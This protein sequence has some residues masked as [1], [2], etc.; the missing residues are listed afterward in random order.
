MQHCLEQTSRA[1]L[2]VAALGLCAAGPMRD[3]PSNL[4]KEIEERCNA[5]DLERTP[6][7]AAIAKTQN[8]LDGYHYAHDRERPWTRADDPARRDQAIQVVR[9]YDNLILI[10]NAELT[11]YQSDLTALSA[12]HAS[13]LNNL[14]IARAEAAK[15]SAN[16]GGR[17]DD[18]SVDQVHGL[19]P[20]VGA[21]L[22]PHSHPQGHT[23]GS[24]FSQ[25]GQSGSRLQTHPM[26]PPD[27][28][29]L[30]RSVGAQTGQ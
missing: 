10:R 23:D 18:H 13:C 30:R 14:A 27:T 2:A 29:A 17:P 7:N 15:E 4:V 9:S 11:K 12:H 16:L 24:S 1:A 21:P 8:T 20:P 25:G 26:S 6:L 28:D 3:A 5:I 22:P 19:F